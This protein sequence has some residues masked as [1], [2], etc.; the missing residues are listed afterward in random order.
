[1]TSF[2]NIHKKYFKSTQK[3]AFF[4]SFSSFFLFF[5]VFFWL[6]DKSEES[7]QFSHTQLC[8][9]KATRLIKLCFRKNL[10]VLTYNLHIGA[11]MTSLFSLFV[12]LVYGSLN[13]GDKKLSAHSPDKKLSSPN[14][15]KLLNFSF[16]SF[17]LFGLD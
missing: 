4:P 10:F 9:I 14:A 2:S 6:A 12:L 3:I 7:T 1:M 16:S 11:S 17:R 13:L 5:L 15:K 8:S